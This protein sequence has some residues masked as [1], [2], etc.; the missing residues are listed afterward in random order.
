MAMCQL[1]VDFVLPNLH[2]MCAFWLM[3]ES[4][5]YR[6]ILVLVTISWGLELFD[7]FECLCV[8]VTYFSLIFAFNWVWWCVWDVFLV[9]VC[10]WNK[11]VWEGI[12]LLL[13]WCKKKI[14]QNFCSSAEFVQWD[15]RC[16][17]A[18]SQPIANPRI[19]FCFWKK[20]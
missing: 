1:C 3:N 16:G 14:L 12:S 4:W 11:C 7:T 2:C 6:K 18:D 19:F 13:V 9:L 8:N 20:N 10:D 17:L 15:V 5:T